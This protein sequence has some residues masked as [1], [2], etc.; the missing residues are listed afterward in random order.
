MESYICRCG[1]KGEFE[2]PKY[3]RTNYGDFC[4]DKC[5]EDAIE[6]VIGVRIRIACPDDEELYDWDDRIL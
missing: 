2:A 3:P 4:S 5:L 1:A 6:D